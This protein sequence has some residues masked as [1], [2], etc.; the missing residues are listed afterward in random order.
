MGSPRFLVSVIFSL[1]QKSALTINCYTDFFMNV[2]SN[3]SLVVRGDV[4]AFENK[5][6]KELIC[7]FLVYFYACLRSSTTISSAKVSAVNVTNYRMKSLLFKV[8]F[9]PKISLM[10]SR[11]CK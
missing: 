8:G 11:C 6:S 2:F 1:S 10:I 3:R 7:Y 9:D 4:E 5:L